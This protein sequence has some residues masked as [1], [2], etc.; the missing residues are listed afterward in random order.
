MT[1][2]S[3]HT[4]RDQTATVVSDL[5][6]H[7]GELVRAEAELA[8][9]EFM[10]EARRAR[11]SVTFLLIGTATTQCGVLFLG[12]ALPAALGV[13]VL[14]ITAIA[15]VVIAIGLATTL[16]GWLHVARPPFERTRHRLSN[17]EAIIH[18]E[19]TRH[20]PPEESLP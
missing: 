2:H 12:V 3:A 7:A 10:E 6:R 8:R 11:R 18:P 14:E 19:A 4:E 15:A 20:A 17:P 5:L 13:G 9:D 16:F 1:Q